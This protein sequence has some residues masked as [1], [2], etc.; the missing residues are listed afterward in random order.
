MLTFNNQEWIPAGIYNY[1]DVTVNRVSYVTGFAEDIES[2]EEKQRLWK[3]EEPIP[4]P[5]P[6]ATEE[7]LKKL[8]EEKEKKIAEETEEVH[9]VARRFGNKMY[10][11]GSNF[12]NTDDRLKLRFTLDQRTVE[13]S[14]IF[15]NHK[16]LA[17]NIPDMGEDLEFGEYKVYVEC[18][19]NG[20]NFT[21]NGNYF[22][23]N[24]VDRN[25]PEEELNKNNKAAA[26]KK[27]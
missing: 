22:M 13:V 6:E 24:C 8:E 9:T 26:K 14:P 10:V 23:Y 1:H 5:N 19:V 7:E 21:T 18:T 20:E 16:K 2:E 4:P 17:C 15:K 12:V 25:I 3:A 27:K 11:H